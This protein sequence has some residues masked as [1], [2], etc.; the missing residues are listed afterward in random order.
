MSQI[1]PPRADERA[2]IADDARRR[3]PWRAAAVLLALAALALFT[4]QSAHASGAVSPTVDAKNGFPLW[5]EDAA[6]NRVAQCLD[7]NDA[8]CVVL[9][10]DFFNPLL[11][12]VFPA[13]E[14][15]CAT[16]VDPAKCN[17]PDEFFYTSADSDRVPTPGCG[18]LSPPGFAS[19]R[20]ALE[21]AFGSATG[22]PAPGQQIVF[23]R[24]R[25][26][27][28]NGLCPN[29]LYTFRTPFGDV[30][31]TTDETGGIKPNAGTTDIGCLAG[32]GAC[33]FSSPTASLLFGTSVAGG[34]LASSPP[35]P[36]GVL[37]D[38]ATPG[39]IQQ[40]RKSGV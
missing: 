33:N 23:G 13:T 7:P 26:I 14:A 3:H 28:K 20:L 10:S 22:A 38:G 27:V 2:P 15:D 6:G 37:G 40:D 32:A 29:T 19:L 39:P 36:G 9:P 25:V 35:P 1:G 34:F 5:Y 16:P 8:A 31:L 30:P 21:G 4:A 17:F 24:T 18:A 12:T 11:P